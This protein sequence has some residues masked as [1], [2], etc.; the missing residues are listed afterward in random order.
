MYRDAE[1]II[2]VPLKDCIGTVWIN[3]QISWG[4]HL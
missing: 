2:G 1:E 3:S 4:L